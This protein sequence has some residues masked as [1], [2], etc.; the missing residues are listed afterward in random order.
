MSTGL[1]DAYNLAW[2]LA[3]VVSQ[4]ADP[5]L[6]D[7]YEA[8]R[9]P[10]ADR[11]LSTT[12]RAFRLVVSDTASTEPQRL[13]RVMTT[14]HV[15]TCIVGGGTGWPDEFATVPP[16]PTADLLR[17]TAAAA[18]SCIPLPAGLEYFVSLML[19]FKREVLRVRRRAPP[20][21]R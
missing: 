12:D 3:L 19:P 18:R 9:L 11:L 14:V 15:Q 10:V 7:T 4:R 8:E 17:G 21:P 6:L 13:E 1:Q 5:A 20:L 2:K 16:N